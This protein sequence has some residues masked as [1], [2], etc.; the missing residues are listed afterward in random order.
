MREHR[1]DPLERADARP[2]GEA[3][4]ADVIEQVAFNSLLAGIGLDGDSYFYT[5]PLRQVRDLPYPLRRPGDTALHPVPAPPPSDERLR[6]SYLSCFCC[7]PN[8]ARTLARFHELAASVSREGIHV[9]LYGGSV[10]RHSDETGRALVLR[11]ESDYPWDGT[12]R[13]VV[14]E[15]SGGGVPST[16]ASPAGPR[17]RR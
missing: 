16:C 17:A 3:R 11:E 14:E 5:N 12:I 8:T 6:E 1:H 2:H 4:Y 15:A 7:P 9:H 13:F 10:L